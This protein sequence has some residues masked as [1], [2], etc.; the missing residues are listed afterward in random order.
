[1]ANKTILP[2]R[3]GRA[4]CRVARSS[5]VCVVFCRSLF[6]L[7]PLAIVLSDLLRYIDS[8]YSF[9]IF[10]LFFQ[11]IDMDLTVIFQKCDRIGVV[12]VSVLASSAVDRVFEPRSGSNQK[13]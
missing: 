12:M 6:V 10:K 8:D 9:G 13:L 11:D 5:I 1:M 3:K 7:C 2:C 4:T